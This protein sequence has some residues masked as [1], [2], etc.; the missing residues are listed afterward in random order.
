MKVGELAKLRT[1]YGFTVR[2]AHTHCASDTFTRQGDMRATVGPRTS[3]LAVAP[4]SRLLSDTLRQA[5]SAHTPQ[6][7]RFAGAL[8]SAAAT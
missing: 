1:G 5:I 3:Q 7:W 6:F 2:A 8:S 4:S